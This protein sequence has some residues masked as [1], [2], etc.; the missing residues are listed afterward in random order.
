MDIW[1]VSVFWVLSILLLWIF[2]YKFLCAL[3]FSSIGYI[4]RSGR[5]GSYITLCLI[6]W[7]TATLFSKAAAP[8]YI[9]T[10]SLSAFR[11]FH[12]FPILF[13]FFDSSHSSGCEVVSHC[14]LIW[15]SLMT[16]D[17]GYP[18]RCFL[19]I[20]LSLGKCLSYLPIF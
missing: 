11:V 7:G 18:C 14:D 10:S 3:V 4:P 16:N 2:V 20:C 19:V 12:I 15:S 9:P 1:P 13:W 6:F 17:I 8:F 5:A